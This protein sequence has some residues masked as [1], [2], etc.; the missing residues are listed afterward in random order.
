MEGDGNAADD[1]AG[2]R[3]F[4]PLP[5]HGGRRDG[6]PRTDEEHYIS[7]HSLRM[8]GDH[9][10][11]SVCRS[12]R[13]Y[14]NPLPPHGGRPRLEFHTWDAAA[15]SIHSLRMEGDVSAVS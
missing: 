10:S 7:I 13:R 3:Y 15:I 11:G 4:N 5:P 2:E 9:W 14:F 8:E 12:R 1:P 6:T